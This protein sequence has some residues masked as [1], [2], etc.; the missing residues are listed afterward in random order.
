LEIFIIVE[1][2]GFGSG[3]KEGGVASWIFIR[4][5]DKVEG[6]LMV[7]F[8][9]LIFPVASLPENFSAHVFVCNV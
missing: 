9:R 7:L 5:T 4:G 2:M 1:N 8:L 6:G 3:V